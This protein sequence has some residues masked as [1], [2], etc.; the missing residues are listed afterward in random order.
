VLVLGA[1]GVAALATG[2]VF[3][4]RYE[5]ENNEAEGLC[6]PDN[7]CSM[8]DLQK[9]TTLYNEASRDRTIYFV[10]ASAGAV[11]LATATYL[12]WRSSHHAAPPKVREA[13][14]RITALAP[15]KGERTIGA[16]LEAIW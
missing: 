9:H 1:L 5:L 14:P 10:T 12:W 4:V 3:A 15:A 8:M 13:T 6:R 11:T 16:V 2:A 7:Q